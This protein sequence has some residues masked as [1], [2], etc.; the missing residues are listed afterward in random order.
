MKSVLWNSLDLCNA[1][2]GKLVGKSNWNGSGISINTKNT[3]VGDVFIALKGNKKDGHEFINEAFEKGAVAAIVN[4]GFSKLLLSRCYVLVEDTYKALDELGKNA[5]ERSNA[6]LIGITG[7]VG[8]TTTKDYLYSILNKN[9][10]CFANKGNHNNRI[11]VPLSLSQIDKNTKF[12]IQ[13]MGMSLPGEIKFL[14]NY[15]KP[16]CSIITS[17]GGS[18]LANF[19]NIKEI[20]NTKAEIFYGMEKD[21]LV[22]LPG[23]CK[24]L[25]ILKSKAYSLG[26]KNILYFGKTKGNDAQILSTKFKYNL[27]DVKIILMGQEVNYKIHSHQP[28]N[29]I[30]STAAILA[31]KAIGLDFEEIKSSISNLYIREGRGNIFYLNHPS[32]SKVTLVNDS[33]NASFQST[34]SAIL[35]LRNLSLSPPLL[36]LGDMLELG[37]F[38]EIEHN[39]LIPLIKSIKP[40][41][42]VAIGEQMSKIAKSLETNYKTICFDS[43][44]IAINEVPNLIQNNDLILIKGSNGMGLNLVV[45]SIKDYFH[46]LNKNEKILDKENSN[47]A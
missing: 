7:S 32:G 35:S 45:N 19:N 11:G 29:I 38:S 21:G 4:K 28:H 1:V 15:S 14:S 34:A 10:L 30:N 33:Y 37:K 47:V 40:R 20:A 12:A 46:D 22:I 6:T 25:E 24:Y 17:I 3:Q 43:T 39:K 9:S 8:K 31:A 42:L 2:K 26:L 5:R 18:H 41:L 36:I 13:E 44:N 23:D 27:I 16:N